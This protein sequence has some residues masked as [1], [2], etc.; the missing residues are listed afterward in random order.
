MRDLW[1]KIIYTSGARVYSL[2]TNFAILTITAR[3]LGPEGR[4]ILA[5]ITTWVGMF[6]M[7][8]H[9]SLGQVA[10]YRATELRK[11]AWLAPMLGS[12]LFLDA[13][14]TL[15]GW[16]IA[17][18]LYLVTQGAVFNNLTLGVL[19]IGFLVLPF[20]IWERYGSSLLTTIDKLAVYNRA[21]MIGRTA[22]VLMVLLAWWLNW[23]VP[24]VLVGTLLSQIVVAVTGIGCLFA[25]SERP[26]RPDRTTIKA[27][28]IGG[29][30]LHFNAIGDILVSS[31][32]I[33]VINHYLTSAETGYY[34]LA[35]QLM[36][37]LLVVSRAA[38]MVIYGKVAQLGPDGAWAYH[39]GVVLLLT[40][41]MMGIAVIAALLAPWAI[42]FVVGDDFAP[43]VGIFQLLLIALI[44]MNFSII[45]AAQWIG[46][47]MFLQVS[48]IALV[49]GVLNLI[50]NLVLVPR[51]G[52]YGPVWSTLVTYVISVLVNGGMAVWCESRYRQ[53]RM[54]SDKIMPAMTGE[55][56]G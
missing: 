24:G 26:A 48:V 54:R 30:K 16:G 37:V 27:L 1:L 23:G 35:V 3:W 5:A 32:G 2:V 25:C 56:H 11:Q 51:Y 18:I 13:V 17:L 41:G 46:R 38:S 9:L 55:F 33:L 36:S 14:I 6:S 12:L 15:L 31:I 53:R 8:G 52:V 42:P 22:G 39:R 44:G 50:A 40:P 47:G 29:L 28:L 43:S 20:T 4:G 19:I 21:Q 49:L 10:I 45:M 34:Q 7:F